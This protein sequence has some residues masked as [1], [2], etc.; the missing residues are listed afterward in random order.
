MRSE[1]QGLLPEDRRMKS[2][3]KESQMRHQCLAVLS[4]ALLGLVAVARSED[5]PPAPM[6]ADFSAPVAIDETGQVD[7]VGELSGVKS[8]LAEAV[9]ARLEKVAAVPARHD[10]AAIEARMVMHGRVILTPVDAEDYSMALSDLSL[11]PAAATPSLAMPPKYPPEAYTRGQEGNVE[12]QLGVDEAGQIT[13]I[14]TISRTHVSLEK[15]VRDAVK[16]WTFKPSGEA[17]VFSVPVRFRLQDK[18]PAP[19]LPEFECQLPEG[20]A[21]IVGQSGCIQKIDVTG[22]R[23]YRGTISIP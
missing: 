5:P 13:N 12:L 17:A 16:K 15:A 4:C 10:D 1:L 21:Y 20:Q 6:Y 19:V 14:R 7:V 2:K 11:M 23:V 22:F 8:P 9:S 18:R 3:A